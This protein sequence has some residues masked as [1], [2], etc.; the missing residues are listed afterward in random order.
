MRIRCR[1]ARL[2]CS[3][4]RNCDWGWLGREHVEIPSGLETPYKV[5]PIWLLFPAT[6]QVFVNMGKQTLSV[7]TL[8]AHMY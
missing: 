8:H 4:R 5:T 3:R 2:G 6:L 7:L 1:T